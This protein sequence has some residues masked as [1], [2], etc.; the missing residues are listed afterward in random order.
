[1]LIGVSQ[2]REHLVGDVDLGGTEDD[3]CIAGTVE[4]ELIAAEVGNVLDG[5]VDFLLDGRHKCRALLEELTLG[6]KVF[7][8]QFGGFLLFGDDGILTGFLLLL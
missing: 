2:L 8:L 1:M 4:D 6:T 3:A 7:L 5:V